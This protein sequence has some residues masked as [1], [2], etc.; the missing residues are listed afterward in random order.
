MSKTTR[1]VRSMTGFGSASAPL[2]GGRLTIE[3]RSVNQRFLDVRVTAPRE[4]AP[5]EA[6]CRELVG[7]H[8]A[9]GRVEVYVSRNAPTRGRTRV[10][11]NVEAARDY[12]AAWRKVAAELG[13]RSAL[14][15][16]LLRG[17]EIFE[18]VETPRDLRS[19]FPAASR[20]LARALAT[21]DQAR[22]R[23]GRNL[24]RDMLQRGARLVAIERAIRAHAA[25]VAGELQ[26]KVNDRLQNLLKGST[27]D[28]ARV[29][30]EVAY[31]AERSD[32]TEELV[33]LRSHLEEL[34]TLLGTGGAVGKQV[35]F[36]LQ[37]THREVNTIGSKVNQLEITRLVVEAKGE[38]ERLREQVQN[39]E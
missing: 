30:Q 19:E 14:D 21:L 37:E 28:P 7:K 20:V 27:V 13:I 22:R 31:L 38:I 33:R 9:R 5:W 32:V 26:A 15:L 11:L 23:E 35:E 12:A 3:L 34:R 2:A 1:G 8:V 39:V 25:T 10:V 16:G 17:A 24:Q 4:Y 29:A 6:A 18:T 36:L